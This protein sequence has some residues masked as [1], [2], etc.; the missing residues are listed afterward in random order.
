MEIVI[1]I[2]D[3]LKY[4]EKYPYHVH[5]FAISG[6]HNC[7][8]AGGHLDPDG[9]GVEGYVCNS[10]QL[11]KCEVGDLSGKYGPL[12]PNKDGSVS[13]HIFDHSLKWNGPAGIT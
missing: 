2:K 6:N 3:G 8:T 4:D 10:N 11:N 5:E 13:E 1:E 9:F 12:E 7:S